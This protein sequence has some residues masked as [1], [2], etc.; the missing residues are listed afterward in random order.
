MAK[1]KIAITLA[2]SIFYNPGSIFPVPGI[3]YSDRNAYR[4]PSYHRLDV[5]FNYKF[6]EKETFNHSISLNL[7]NVYNNTNPFYI[8]LVQD[9]DNSVFEFKQ[10]SL[11]KFFP[12]VTYRFAFQ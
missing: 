4:L 12:S 9:P 7:Y 3:N 10:F 11:F 1:E 5:T 6:A 2:E 8:T